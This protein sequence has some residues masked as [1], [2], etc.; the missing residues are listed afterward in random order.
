MRQNLSM[1]PNPGETP[2]VQNRVCRLVL[3]C[4]DL[5][6]GSTWLTRALGIADLGPVH[7]EPAF[8]TS[9]YRVSLGAGAGKNDM[10]L[11][12]MA[13]TTPD[14]PHAS[15]FGLGTSDTLARIQHRPALIGWGVAAQDEGS[16]DARVA[17]LDGI[18]GGVVPLADGRRVTSPLDGH[19]IE[20]GLVPQL[21]SRPEQAAS[22][23]CRFT[24]MEAAHPNPAKVQYLLT[25][26][27]VAGALVLTA[28]PPYSGMTMCA[29]LEGPAGKRTLMS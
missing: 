13:R 12:L 16:F 10:V 19:P 1:N 28:S 27:G 21:F 29:Y 17:T 26:L 15:W 24:W 3:G 8:G 9:E 6:R 25:E 20:G 4:A 7:Q 5:S 23:D 22:G 18:L 14:A 11:C 2:S